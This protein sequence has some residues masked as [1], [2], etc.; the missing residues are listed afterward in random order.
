ERGCRRH[1]THARSAAHDYWRLYSVRKPKSQK[2]QVAEQKHPEPA[3]RSRV[4]PSDSCHYR[5]TR[6]EPEAVLFRQAV[7]VADRLHPGD[8]GEVRQFLLQPD[9]GR[10]RAGAT[11]CD[12]LGLVRLI[13][14]FSRFRNARN[15]RLTGACKNRL[16]MERIWSIPPALS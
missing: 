5:R 8:P 3:R 2:A 15:S 14:L 10:R 16:T 13:A 7:L 4:C 11:E 6:R 12:L 9:S 1:S